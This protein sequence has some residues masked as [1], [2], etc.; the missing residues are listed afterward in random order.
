[1]NMNSLSFDYN[2]HITMRRVV[3]GISNRK[4]QWGL[5]RFQE[6]NGSGR[7]CRRCKTGK[8]E[9][10]GITYKNSDADDEI[11]TLHPRCETAFRQRKESAGSSDDPTWTLGFSSYRLPINCTG[12]S[13]LCRW[14]WS[15]QFFS[16]FFNVPRWFIPSKL[17]L[18]D[19]G[20]QDVLPSHFPF[21]NSATRIRPPGI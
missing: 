16:F 1:M 11:R 12:A 18:R 9:N 2:F 6:R 20:H 10:V 8:A 17:F 15:L 14:Y 3:E 4:E 21:Q 7:D 13:L 19:G 5:S